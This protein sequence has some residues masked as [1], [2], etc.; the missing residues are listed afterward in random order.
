MG[1]ETRVKQLKL[2]SVWSFG[3]CGAGCR[4][5]STPESRNGLART[6]LMLLAIY[7]VMAPRVSVAISNHS[8]TEQGRAAYR[9]NVRTYSDLDG[10][11]LSCHSKLFVSSN[12]E[13]CLAWRPGGTATCIQS[14]PQVW[15]DATTN[16]THDAPHVPASTSKIRL[17]EHC[18]G[19]M[20]DIVAL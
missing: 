14:S 2:K 10:R 17:L 13:A 11:R 20:T 7:W 18:Y 4:G 9:L 1:E 6:V 16:A 19:L 15:I 5:C 12:N 8:K 3:G